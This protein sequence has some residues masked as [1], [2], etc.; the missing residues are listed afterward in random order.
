MNDSLPQPA[1]LMYLNV[2]VRIP[3]RVEDDDG[4]CC[5]QVDA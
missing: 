1:G 3:V 4:V 5:G 2:V